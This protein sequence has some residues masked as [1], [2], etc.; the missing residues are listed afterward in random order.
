MCSDVWKHLCVSAIGLGCPEGKNTYLRS[1]LTPQNVG[2]FK[3][4]VMSWACKLVVTVM[5]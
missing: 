1:L 4:E 5:L 3:A 2:F